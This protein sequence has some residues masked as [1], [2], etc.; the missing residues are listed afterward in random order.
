MSKPNRIFIDGRSAVHT[1]SQGRIDAWQSYYQG[2]G[3]TMRLNQSS[4]QD[5]VNTSE[6]VFLNG[7]PA[8]LVGSKTTHS[9]GDAD[10]QG[11]VL[12]GGLK[13]A[14][15]IFRT[16]SG[17]VIIEGRESVRA[18][19][20]C[21]PN[22]GNGPLVPVIQSGDSPSK[23]SISDMD[24]PKSEIPEP[25]LVCY[26]AFVQFM[27][28]QANQDY[29][30]LAIYSETEPD[31]NL[32][33]NRVKQTMMNEGSLVLKQWMLPANEVTW[34]AY[35]LEKDL[36]PGYLAQDAEQWPAIKTD[37]ASHY[38]IPLGKLLG[39]KEALSEA[40]PVIEF[41]A[42]TPVDENKTVL[43]NGWLYLFLEGNL[44]REI[45][46]ISCDHDGFP[47]YHF[48]DVNLLTQQGGDYRE[49]TT[50]GRMEQILLPV[51]VNGAEVHLAYAFSASQWPWSKI[52]SLGGLS[53]ERLRRCRRQNET[54]CAEVSKETPLKSINLRNLT[55]ETLYSDSDSPYPEYT[56]PIL[57]VAF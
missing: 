27:G 19:D 50:Q 4:T 18:F 26:S 32:Q 17:S 10:T 39:K 47:T 37:W 31:K 24:F 48:S 11:G 33:I 30:I 3:V 56:G 44:W 1:G 55:N 13:G 49:A 9:R 16:G 6:R 22:Q 42:L 25:G 40:A 21:E 36:A 52:L 29:G 12:N 46:V 14:E 15:T 23:E 28:V 57:T 7:H 2:H 8:I 51:S 5:A 34:Q 20:L 41:V 54:T 35:L 38:P 53:S 43:P 45:R